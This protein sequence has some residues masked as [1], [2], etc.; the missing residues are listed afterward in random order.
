METD[1]MSKTKTQTQTQ[2]QTQ[3]PTQTHPQIKTINMANMAKI[4]TPTPKNGGKP[5]STKTI[6]GSAFFC[7]HVGACANPQT[8]NKMVGLWAITQTDKNLSVGTINTQTQI[9]R[10]T[11]AIL[12]TWGWSGPTPMLT[13]T[14][15]NKI[16]PNG[17][18]PHAEC[19]I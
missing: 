9:I 4:K 3:T 18:P 15:I 8:D 10:E 17:V 7:L 16:L 2:T 19:V 1:T 14:Q 12:K 13:Q 5:R 11:M 6:S